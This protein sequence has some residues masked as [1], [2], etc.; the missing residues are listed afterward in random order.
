MGGVTKDP[1]ETAPATVM[2]AGVVCTATSVRVCPPPAS[3]KKPVF[4]ST[5]ERAPFVKSGK[6]QKRN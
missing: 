5:V 1:R 2:S 4:L 3:R 6:A